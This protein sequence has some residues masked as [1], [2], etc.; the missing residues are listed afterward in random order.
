[1]FPP[2]VS[3]NAMRTGLTQGLAINPDVRNAC[4]AGDFYTAEM[5]LN[6]DIGADANNHVSYANRAFVMARK[7]RWDLAL[8]D[9]NKV[10]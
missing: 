1:M 5:A 7:S 9:A 6:E 3:Y 4:I 8:R 10:I 2:C